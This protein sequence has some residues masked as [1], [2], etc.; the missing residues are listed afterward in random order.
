MKNYH[1]LMKDGWWTVIRSGNS[2]S[3]ESSHATEE[4][5]IECAKRL[6]H[7]NGGKVTVHSAKELRDKSKG[8][9]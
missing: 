2:S 4:Q 6:A 3:L 7:M 1:V 5:A 9:K 8:G